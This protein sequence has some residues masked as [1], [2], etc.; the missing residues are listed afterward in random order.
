MGTL[1]HLP[2]P[3][4]RPGPAVEHPARRGRAAGPVISPLWPKLWLDPDSWD[5]SGPLVYSVL[6]SSPY[7]EQLFLDVINCKRPSPS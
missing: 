4:E 3:A 2:S 1:S 7:G 6:C 5:F